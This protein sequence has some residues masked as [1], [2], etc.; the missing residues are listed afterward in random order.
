MHG[1][2]LY[3]TLFA[4]ADRDLSGL[5]LPAVV[6]TPASGGG[7]ESMYH[8]AAR[9]LAG[10][11]YIAVTV[12]PQGVGRSPGTAPA[13]DLN[14]YADATVSAL[15]FLLSARNPLH[16]HVD[17][18]RLGA[19]GHSLSARALSWQQGED[20]RLRAIVAW[21]NLSST[22][23][24]DR[25]T[26][27]QG[28]LGGALFSGELMR[29]NAPV[30]PRVPAMGQASDDPGTGASDP[31]RKKFAY[32]HWRRAGIGTMQLVMR[33][34]PH[35]A[36]AQ[37]ATQGSAADSLRLQRL[38]HLTRAWFDLWLREDDAALTRLTS[39]RVLG[40]DAAA[41]YSATFR[42]ALYLPSLGIDCPDLFAEGCLR[43][44]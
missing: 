2:R 9:D 1:T 36:W 43:S 12:D 5:V 20:V 21:D 14:N 29:P 40:E 42:S 18:A 17:R 8:W 24:G 19:A 41:V 28:G 33:D 38:A 7:D 31:E 10:H 26:P 16:A 22:R 32:E 23:H 44:D 6:I 35:E 30:A 34:L 39:R 37:Y 27:S 4:P 11:G 15:D 25:G 13:Q 3:G